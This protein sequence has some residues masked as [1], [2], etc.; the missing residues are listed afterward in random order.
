MWRY[1]GI[2]HRFRLIAQDRGIT[3][4]HIAVARDGTRGWSSLV[5]TFDQ[6]CICSSNV[7]RGDLTL[8]NDNAVNDALRQKP[9]KT[10]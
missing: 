9:A 10:K 8:R 5:V 4:M 3:N 7:P 2:E 1:E 6:A